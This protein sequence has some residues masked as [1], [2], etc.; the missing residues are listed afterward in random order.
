MTLPV[1][2]TLLA[3]ALASQVSAQLIPARQPLES[4]A[5]RRTYVFKNTPQGELKLHVFLPDGW[6]AGQKRSAILMLYGGGFTGGTPDQFE[7]KARYLAGR[8]MVAVTPEYRI[9]NK[10]KTGPDKSIEDGRSAIRWVRMNA[11]AL[12]VDP[13]RVVGSGGSAGGTCVSVAALSDAFEPEGEDR[14]VSS[15]PDVLVLY[16]PA[17]L[18]PGMAGEERASESKLLGAWSI[19]KGSPPMILFFGS[20]DKWLAGGRE[21]ARQ[22]VALGNRAELYIAPGLGHGFFNDS[23]KA[24]NGVPGWHEA[25]LFET[26]VFLTS[27]GYLAG[28][29]T[30]RPSVQLQRQDPLKP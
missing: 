11:A 17:L 8:G 21:V 28:P 12:G 26:D 3:L 5:G 23:S 19:R 22:S 29:P 14:S 2:L 6:A 27:L 10:H 4:S 24:E 16:N 13:A 9:K 7:S 1:S 18:V 25:V 20:K 30:V 15:K